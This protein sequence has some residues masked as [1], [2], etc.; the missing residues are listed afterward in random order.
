MYPEVETLITG[1]Q[2]NTAM[3]WCNESDLTSVDFNS[4]T[5]EHETSSSSSSSSSAD[6]SGDDSND[7]A[8]SYADPDLFVAEN[9]M[10]MP[11]DESDID[12]DE[13]PI[14]T[15]TEKLYE[16][17]EI[18]DRQ[19]ILI[20]V[21]LYIDHKLT[22]ATLQGFLTAIS[23]MLPKNNRL[24][25]TNFKLFNYLATFAPQNIET[26]HYYCK[27][28][29]FYYGQLEDK[30]SA[31]EICS[32]PK[33]YGYFFQFSIEEQIRFLFEK[34]NLAEVLMPPSQRDDDIISDIIDGSEYVRVNAHK[35]IYDLTLILNTDGVS[36]SKSSKMS[37]WPL[38]YMIAEVP[39]HLRESFLLVCGIWYD[40]KKPVMNSFL[41]PIC[42]ELRECF[43]GVKFINP[44]T[45]Q[46]C[47]S[48]VV[49]PFIVG[50]APAR[51]E[52][53]NIL[54]H[55]GRHGCNGCEIKSKKCI[56]IEGTKR[57]RIYPFP[58]KGVVLR[59][60]ERMEAQ[61]KKVNANP[62]LK[63]VKGVK[64]TSIIS[65]VPSLD[66]STCVGPEYM[67]SLLLGVVKLFM[68][69]WFLST[70]EWN[71]QCHVPAINDL[72]LSVRP[73]NI[74]SKRMP[75]DVSLCGSYKAYE[76]MMWLLHY[77]VPILVK[78]LPENRFQHWI[79]L[80][81]AS[82]LLL[83]RNIST[84]DLKK[85]E[86]LLRLFVRD[87]KN[88]YSDRLLTYNTHQLLHLPL[89]VQRWGPLWATS[90]F[91]FENYN[92]FLTNFLHSTNNVGQEL[93]NSIKIYNGYLALQQMV[94]GSKTVASTQQNEF[95]VLG[96]KISLSTLHDSDKQMLERHFQLSNLEIYSK[97]TFRGRIYT[98]QLYK[99]LKTCSYNVDVH[100][101]NQKIL[102]G[103][104]KFFF[105]CDNNSF[106]LLNL[107]TIVHTQMI[108]HKSTGTKLEHIL[109]IMETENLH[110]VNIL[111][112][113][114]MYLL[115][116]V[117]DYICKHPYYFNKVF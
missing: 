45:N 52:I 85:A 79:L 92:G 30:G 58:E 95:K 24:P 68:V 108:Y 80:V 28:C 34:R 59:T 18:D 98:T 72:L 70:A 40:V 54:N 44:K 109:P 6:D 61:G 102:H 14:G 47:S 1:S 60:K 41:Q 11:D 55:N 36:Y 21:K 64:G 94:E 73:P 71:L 114:H 3:D 4:V 31:C 16:G 46:A 49:G 8:N 99:L 37:L 77:S 42:M 29:L 78:Y 82:Y 113:E 104:I 50:D 13:D 66:I 27:N 76:L 106:M 10:S 116:K 117:D 115:T 88:L 101:Q 5:S 110:I 33:G 90:A 112:I 32:S 51:A 12:S 93:V 91:P 105:A 62:A 100:L 111:E 83:Q 56:F 103:A 23:K 17:C 86:I 43:N 48:R 107:F 9:E 57:I 81:L 63:N 65:I 38:M 96:Q 7:E 97:A 75:K 35:Q 2:D 39:E 22:K 15:F 19:A 84:E 74:H 53:Q 20:V 25:K 87:I 67:H 89:F 26:K 69:M